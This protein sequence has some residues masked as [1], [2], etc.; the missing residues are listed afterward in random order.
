MT[1]QETTQH[2]GAHLDTS[3][4]HC[5]AHACGH[6]IQFVI[7][8]MIMRWRMRVMWLMRVTRKRRIQQSGRLP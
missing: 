6:K 8:F 5:P 7:R 4:A 3:E 2:I 1:A